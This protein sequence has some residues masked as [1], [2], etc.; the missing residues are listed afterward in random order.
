M[1]YSAPES[2]DAAIVRRLKEI[3]NP[4]EVI[5]VTNDLELNRRCRNAGASAMSWPQFDSKMQ[6]RS[7]SR[8]RTQKHSQEDVDVEEWMRYFGL[9]NTKS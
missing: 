1:R 4:S 8:Q 9:E 7:A 2:A 5:V 6:S 3:Q